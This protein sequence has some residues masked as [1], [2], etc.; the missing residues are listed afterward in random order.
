MS[1]VTKNKFAEPLD[2]DQITTGW[3]S[4]G[5]SSAIYVDAPGQEWVD[6]THSTNELVMVV[7]G[8]LRM[9]V[10]KEEFIA[11]PGDEVF[12]P[13]NTYHSLYNI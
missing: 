4:R 5:F 7:E 10:G 9:V 12:I 11:N 6:F 3:K 13:R 8:Q 1:C 2:L